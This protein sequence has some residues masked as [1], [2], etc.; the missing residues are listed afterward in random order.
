MKKKTKPS[1]FY[2]SDCCN[3]STHVEGLPDFGDGDPDDVHTLHY[4]CEACQKPCNPISKPGER[5]KKNT[6]WGGVPKSGV[7]FSENPPGISGQ[8][9]QLARTEITRLLADA[10]QGK[11]GTKNRSQLISKLQSIYNYL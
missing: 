5:V 6:H 7:A 9:A 1:Q 10:F 2:L 3:A 11:F 4:V 8:N